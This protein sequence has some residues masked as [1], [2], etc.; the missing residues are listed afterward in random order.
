[1][2]YGLGT[3]RHRQQRNRRAAVYKWLA[4]L[5][6]IVGA[7]YFAYDT[8]IELAQE[9]VVRLRGDLRAQK[10]E[11]DALK[12][13]NA[14]LYLAAQ[15]LRRS[16]TRLAKEAPTGARKNI[17]Q[18]IDSRLAAGIKVERLRA[19]IAAVENERVCEGK[20]VSRRFL[21]RTPIYQGANDS[22]DFAGGAITVTAAGQSAVNPAGSPEAW[23]DPAKPVNVALTRLGGAKAETAGLLPLHAAM[24]VDGTDY[25]FTITAAERQ[26]FV[27]VTGQGCRYP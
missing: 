3:S 21:V 15:E 8:G 22:V 19:V 12:Q 1:M 10:E 14:E 5:I 2:S 25:R 26:G 18:S 13:S 11:I 23:F 4:A 7:G 20:P 27:T 9:E 16:Q 17:L 24:P 6:A